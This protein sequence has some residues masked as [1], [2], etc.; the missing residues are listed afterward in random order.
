MEVATA[1]T[2]EKVPVPT[3]ARIE[4]PAGLDEQFQNDYIKLAKELGFDAGASQLTKE[5]ETMKFKQ[6][7]SENGIQTYEY[8]KVKAYLDDQY[9]DIPWGWRA[10][11][12]KD[13]PMVSNV[14]VIGANLTHDGYSR[15]TKSRQVVWSKDVNGSYLGNMDTALYG[16]PIPYPVLLTIKKIAD[17]FPNT[18]FWVSDEA[19]RISAPLDPFLL[20][21]H[22]GKSYIVERWN[23]PSFRG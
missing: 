7:L 20:V 13:N 1:T 2:V 23:E 11:R 12:E 6:F 22:S 19:K 3:S 9:G 10:L 18:A 14:R 5:L 21:R 15:D 17:A 4:L 16:K 8:K